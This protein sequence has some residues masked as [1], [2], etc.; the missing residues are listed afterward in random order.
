MN[1][2][3]LYPEFPFSFWSVPN[4]IR[5]KGLKTILYPLG[6]LTVARLLPK[7]WKIRLVD[8]NA[9][10]LTEKDW[11]W[12][13]IV[14]L[15]GMYVQRNG[16][17]NLIKK[18]KQMG[19][20]VVAGG[21]YP[22]I[23][24][25]EVLSAGCDY[26]FKGEAEGN[27][28]SLISAIQH[29]NTPRIIENVAKPDLTE[30]PIPRFDLIPLNRNGNY[31][32]QTARGCPFNCE[33]CN[34]T[35]LF[36][37]KVRR[38]TPDQIIEELEYLY[39]LG[40]RGH[41]FICDDNF[42]ADRDHA[43]EILER[44]IIWNKHRRL[45]FGFETQASLNLG[46]DIEL[47]NLMTKANIHEIFIGFESLD[48]EVLSQNHKYHNLLEN[49]LTS[50]RNINSNGLSIIAS[51]IIGSDAEKRGAGERICQFIEQSGI[52]VAMANRLLAVPHSNLWK[53]MEKE[54]RL[55]TEYPDETSLTQS[56]IIPKRPE[57]EILEDLRYAYN[58]LYDP[59]LYLKRTYRFNVERKP[60]PSA[61]AKARGEKPPDWLPE[62][63]R[64]PL[65]TLFFR[66]RSLMILIW[67]QGILPQHR[68]QFW[69]Q[70]RDMRRNNPSRLIRYFIH[71]AYGEDLFLFRKKA[72]KE[73]DGIN[74]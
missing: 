6:L 60:N 63:K 69:R 23:S 55:K 74:A 58:N 51:F 19:K 30:S 38:K 17:L 24:P 50:V 32:I 46:R 64:K 48:E 20:I 16:M 44:L 10:R 33:F 73:I 7:D 15:S 9:E 39:S 11:R 68:K 26:V 3:M 49:P 66:L 70:W 34:I 59:L 13:Q 57:A 36:G 47:I 71:C 28:E 25:N 8:L 52:P 43:V 65:R 22:S 14:M 27:I 2:L 12:A 62:P 21:P 35:H 1:V 42:I 40:A 45:P 37:R 72:Q 67:R 5:F 41:V 56:N 54:G 18:A 4:L 61:L 53:R 29:E 31:S